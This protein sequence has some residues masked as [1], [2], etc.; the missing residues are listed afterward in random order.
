MKISLN[1][2]V[3]L[4]KFLSPISK[5]S[6]KCVISLYPDHVQSMVATS[7]SNPILYANVKTTCD[8]EDKKEVILNIRD[9][10]KLIRVLNCI[11]SDD[12]ELE[13]NS[14]NIEYKS[15]NMNFKYYLL[16]DGVIEKC[17][18]KQEK[19]EQLQFDSDFPLGKDAVS[20]IIKGTSFANDSNKLYFYMKDGNVYAELT[21][22]EIANTDSVSYFI[23][24][25]YSGTEIKKPILIDVE[26]FKMF[27]GL[28]SN[29]ITKINTKNKIIM[30]KFEGD[31]YTLQYI[32]SPKV[33]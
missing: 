20:N 8:L 12:I 25:E 19:I 21:D 24:N 32:V 3:I 31:N 26:I 33:R 30:F 29:I 1:K 10:N 16:S 22:K 23:T 4:N 18:I 14:N 28:N 11:T 6:E 2:N 9:V 17:P 15:L 13:I 27:S 5:V 7:D